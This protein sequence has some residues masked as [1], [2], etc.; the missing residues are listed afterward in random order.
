M[1]R[2]TD[3]FCHNT[4]GASERTRK[5][6]AQRGVAFVFSGN[7]AAAHF[8]RPER[9]LKCVASNPNC[10]RV[11]RDQPGGFFFLFVCPSVVLN[12]HTRAV[13]L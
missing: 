9:H 11:D 6:E 1:L 5:S 12:R 2:E 8:D 13:S 10:Q 3:H 7:R 4:L